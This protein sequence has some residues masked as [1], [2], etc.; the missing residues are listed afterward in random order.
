[1]NKKELKSLPS[2]AAA[3]KETS[4]VFFLCELGIK[5]E[6]GENL[7]HFPQFIYQELEWN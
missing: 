6:L 3:K 2:Q 4:L 1:M 7:R 5:E